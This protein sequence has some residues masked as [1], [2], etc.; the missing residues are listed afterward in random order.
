MFVPMTLSAL[1]SQFSVN[2]S[3]G[4]YLGS[5]QEPTLHLHLLYKFERVVPE[6]NRR[7]VK[8]AVCHIA[9]NQLLFE[10]NPLSKG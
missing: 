5:E 1:R 9:L 6:I 2:F 4:S 7:V 10:G 3:R 8:L